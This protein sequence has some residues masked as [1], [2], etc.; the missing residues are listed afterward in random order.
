MA[1]PAKRSLDSVQS[2]PAA[3]LVPVG[4]GSLFLFVAGLVL[5]FFGVNLS[6]DASL[7]SS[8]A[9]FF[10]GLD[11]TP[12]MLQKLDYKIFALS[13]ILRNSG[14]IISVVS[15][16]V[17]YATLKGV[18]IAGRISVGANRFTAFLGGRSGVSAF[19]FIIGSDV[20]VISFSLV[21]ATTAGFFFGVSI[22]K[23]HL[24]FSL[25]AGALFVILSAGR[26]FP[27]RSRMVMLLS[28]AVLSAVSASALLIS[29]A[30]Y[31][32]AFDSQAYHQE[33]MIY[34]AEGWNPVYESK[35]G[36]IDYVRVDDQVFTTSKASA[37]IA[38]N[39]YKLTGDPE[40]GKAVNLLLI[41]ASFCLSFSAFLAFRPVSA[42]YS[43]LLS[44]LVSL[45]PV[46]VY[47]SLSFYVDGLMSSVIICAFS[48]FV[49]FVRR[50]DFLV[51]LV[52]GMSV[53][54]LAAVKLTGLAYAF[55]VCAGAALYVLF[56]ISAKE[57]L[58][59]ASVLLL[60]GLLSFF[61]FSFNPF[62]TNHVNHGHIFHPFYGPSA[63]TVANHGPAYIAGMNNIQK[64]LFSV[65][66]ESENFYAARLVEPRIKFP[67]F[68]SAK[69][70]A[71]FA[72]TDVR[73][74]GFGPLF[75]AALIVSLALLFVCFFWENR[76]AIIGAAFVS[77][78]LIMVFAV[79]EAWWARFVPQFF[80][81]PFPVLVLSAYYTQS[82]IVWMR[83]ALPALLIAN[84][85]LV[86]LPYYLNQMMTT[87]SLS[88]QLGQMKALSGRL[89]VYPPFFSTSLG[90]RMQRAGIDH[91]EVGPEYF[92]TTPGM[93]A[94]DFSIIYYTVIE[95]KGQK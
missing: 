86:G 22:S 41:F 62:V 53:A 93:T 30:F 16:F 75:G 52:F 29:S 64:G 7:S 69:E 57:F 74:G 63:I 47:Q 81:V 35:R 37:A 4:A 55:F 20:L 40:T 56:F 77:W 12:A 87:A 58:R 3:R 84:L 82:P 70:S 78:I 89:A 19:L 85:V 60:F 2:D 54:V 15:F 31:D 67:L 88:R 9:G 49:I 8:V 65:F 34:M 26:L 14:F 50:K 17:L 38:A 10:T 83:R 11:P 27:D 76:P 43:L 91:I 95:Q 1:K 92:K 80:L 61:C 42:G 79:P 18:D 46:S 72:N 66:S 51:L 13:G 28:L 48:L 73:V 6:S 71:L 45:N 33:N 32:T 39:L 68:F 24:L 90:K 59:T 36:D 25:S 5:I 94:A 23:F 44:L 21:L